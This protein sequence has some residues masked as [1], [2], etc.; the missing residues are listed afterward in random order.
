M[1]AVAVG[2]V[3]SHHSCT[4]LPHWLMQTIH[5][6]VVLHGTRII[7]GVFGHT[8][9]QMAE[10]CQNLPLATAQPLFQG[11]RGPSSAVAGSSSASS[12]AFA[13]NLSVAETIMC[14]PSYTLL[15]GVTSKVT[16][17]AKEDLMPA[18]VAA[19]NLWLPAVAEFATNETLPS[20]FPWS[21]Q[22]MAW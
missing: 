7:T 1:T 14:F 15:F 18:V 8:G 6:T 16:L 19:G 22:Q 13:E 2:I 9:Q 11:W 10:L 20:W 3:D 12:S 21:R 5:D 4:R 17:V